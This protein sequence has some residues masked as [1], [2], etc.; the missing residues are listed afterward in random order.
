MPEDHQVV[1]QD[2]QTDFS[3]LTLVFS[4][5]KSTAKV[6]FEHTEYRLDLP[7]LAIYVLW[8]IVLH[9]LSIVSCH[10]F[11]FAVFARATALCG[12]NNTFDIQPIAA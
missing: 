7:A 8:K 2:A 1:A 3:V 6:S 4:G 11:G 9:L 12:R 5:T 10:C